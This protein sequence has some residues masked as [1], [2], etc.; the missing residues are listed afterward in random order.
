MDTFLRCF[1]NP[2]PTKLLNWLAL[3]E[4]WY[5]TCPHFTISRSPS[6][7]LYGYVLKNYAQISNASGWIFD[8]GNWN[9][10][11]DGCI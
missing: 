11:G 1:A 2:C 7:A 9:N 8:D 6:E 3:A 4:F 5:N 10:G